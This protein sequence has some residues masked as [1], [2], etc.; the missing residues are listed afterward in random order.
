MFSR[1]TLELGPVPASEDCQQVDGI[2]TDYYKMKAE[3][4]RYKEQLEAIFPDYQQ[5][6]CQFAVKTYS[7]DFGAYMEVVIYFYP[8]E[9]EDDDETSQ[10]FAFFVESSLPDTWDDMSIRH[11]EK[12]QSS[13]IAEAF[14]NA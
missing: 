14:I 2:N 6:D 5:Y 13:A 9:Y 7:H 12:W 1:E 3:C 4:N 10:D 8:V 11:F